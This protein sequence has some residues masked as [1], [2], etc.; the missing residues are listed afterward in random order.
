MKKSITLEEVID[1][2]HKSEGVSAE[3]GVA[4]GASVERWI[5]MGIRTPYYA[6]DT[7]DQHPV[8]KMTNGENFRGL[9][10]DPYKI[11]EVL[12]KLESIGAIPVK[13]IFPDDVWD[14]IPEKV[15]FV[16]LDADNYLTIK[17]G[18]EIFVPRL[19]KNGFIAIHD[20]FNGAAPG[21]KRAVDEYF[22]GDEYDLAILK[23]K[24]GQD[25]VILFPYIVYTTGTYIV[26]TGGDK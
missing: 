13:G 24:N 7:Y 22:P 12:A 19:A 4:N 16:Y 25:D 8:C 3:V 21:V 23:N 6:F 17:A 14:R 9:C 1:R 2:Y 15:A 18:L 26:C 5:N 11:D 20:Y 10:T